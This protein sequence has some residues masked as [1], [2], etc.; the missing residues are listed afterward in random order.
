MWGMIHTLIHLIS[1]ACLWPGIALQ[2]S[3]VTENHSFVIHLGLSRSSVL[4][5]SCPLIQIS[6]IRD[7]LLSVVPQA[8]LDLLSWQELER[9]VCGDPEVSV[10]ALRRSGECMDYSNIGGKRSRLMH[11][12]SAR[13]TPPK[14]GGS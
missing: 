9:R 3:I 11:N 10:T 8:V 2:Y 13:H 4:T 12:L 5:V 6:A 1:S 14:H 7:G